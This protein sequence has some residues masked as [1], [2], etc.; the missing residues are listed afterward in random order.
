MS[1][2]RQGFSFVA[3]GCCLVAIDW[4]V[5]VGLTAAGVAP[6]SANI[7]GRFVGALLGFWG[8]GW[9]T[10]GAR[11]APRL[12]RHRFA[13]FAVS[14]I[15]VTLLSTALV[16]LL[17]SRLSLQAAWIA[18]PLVEGSLAIVSFFVSRHWVYR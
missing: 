17:A 8:N 7:A 14:W 2:T 9:I 18:K 6:V 13:R 5:F 10:F 1:I 16:T 12:G 3:V 15:V 4:M 11:G